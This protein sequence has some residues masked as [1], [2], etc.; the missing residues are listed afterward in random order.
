LDLF[1]HL[2]DAEPINFKSVVQDKKLKNAM[3]EE[4]KASYMDKNDT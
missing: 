2:V 3:D 4:I 1:C